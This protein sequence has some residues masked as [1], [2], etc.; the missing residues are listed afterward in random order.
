[1]V[2]V[3][4]GNG[5]VMDEF[6]FI[7]S[8]KQPYYHQ[9]S[10][11]K[12]IDDDAAVFHT[13][14]DVVTSVDTFVEGIHF[15]KKTMTP[16]HI[17]YRVLA[18]NISDMAAMGACP[19]FYLVSVV[20]PKTYSMREIKEI[21]RGMKMLSD[22]Y[23]MDLIGGDTVSGNELTISVTVIGYVMNGMAR[24]RSVAK[25]DDIVFVTGTLG[26]SQAGL[27]ILLKE[28]QVEEKEYFIDRH[29]LPSPRVEFAKG[30]E[31]IPRVA[32]NDISDGLASE[33]NEIAKAS[34]VTLVIDDN[35]IP[36]VPSF[37]QFSTD[38]QKKWKYFGG[39][40]FELIGTVSVHD[41]D[42]VLKIAEKTNTNV[43]N[44]G[45]VT[46]KKESSVY[47]NYQTKQIPLLK[48]GYN[49]LSR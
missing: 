39:E 36:V 23:Q 19:K 48:K 24:Y 41:W 5:D 9:S 8:I 13:T 34:N 30:L 17:G 38:L 31:Q 45:Y 40:D 43:T 10:L 26:D 44:V 14:N 4:N 29:R 12:G 49:H 47:V 37:T 1:M 35:S 7:D 28:L 46:T 20:I 33:A 32:L 25:E 11:I 18:A 6:S 27:Y 42:K 22:N 16:L 15:S 2:I 21:F 3:N